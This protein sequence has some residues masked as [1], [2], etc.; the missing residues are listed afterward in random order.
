MNK[1]EVILRNKI[2]N[3]F[4]NNLLASKSQ[5]EIR[6]YASSLYELLQEWE[7]CPCHRKTRIKTDNNTLIRLCLY[8]VCLRNG[9]PLCIRINGAPTKKL[10]DFIGRSRLALSEII[11]VWT[12]QEIL[13]RISY[14]CKQDTDV[15]FGDKMSLTDFLWM[16]SPKFS[17]SGFFLTVPSSNKKDVYNK[18]AELFHKIRPLEKIPKSVL[19][20]RFKTFCQTKDIDPHDVK[21]VLE[22]YYEHRE[23]KG[24]DMYI[25]LAETSYQFFD[26]YERLV[27]AKE[28]E[29]R[30]V[31]ASGVYRSDDPNF[32]DW[33]DS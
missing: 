4:L 7:T 18:L 29:S 16:E 13:S 14:R 22:W 8:Y 5:E 11:R 2:R 24:D 32:D 21:K 15:T 6:G 31:C 30:S 9:V 28:N 3:P 17:N 25:P 23:H 19:A 33:L 1:I 10:I 26:K 20:L 27:R 12:H